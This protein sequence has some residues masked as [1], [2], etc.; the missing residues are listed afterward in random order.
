MVLISKIL[1]ERRTPASTLG[2]LVTIVLTPYIGVRLY[3]II[4]GRK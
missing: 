4:G 2:W 1:K 3:F